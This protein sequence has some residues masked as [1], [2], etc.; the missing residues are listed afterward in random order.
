MVRIACTCTHIVINEVTAAVGLHAVHV[1]RVYLGDVVIVVPQVL[2][3]RCGHV[4]GG[5]RKRLLID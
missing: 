1:V 4:P 5:H 2:D 3:H